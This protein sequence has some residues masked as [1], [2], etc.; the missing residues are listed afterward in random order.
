MKY[1]EY[2]CEN[3][4]CYNK[5]F[6]SLRNKICG[7]VILANFEVVSGAYY[8]LLGEDS[9]CFLEYSKYWVCLRHCIHVCIELSMRQTSQVGQSFVFRVRNRR[10][11]GRVWCATSGFIIKMFVVSNNFSPLS[12][13]VYTSMT[14]IGRRKPQHSPLHWTPF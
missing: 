7:G 10:V 5:C 14:S 8:S 4:N 12:C 6:T 13:S 1:H 11:S 2:G 9:F 3:K